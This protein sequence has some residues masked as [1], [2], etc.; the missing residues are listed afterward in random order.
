MIGIVFA[1][2]GWASGVPGYAPYQAPVYAS[3]GVG[4][5]LNL[6]FSGVALPALRFDYGFSERNPRGVF[7]FRIGT[8]F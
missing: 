7:S 8:V 3:G 6:G 4:V 2:V 1:D 5:Q